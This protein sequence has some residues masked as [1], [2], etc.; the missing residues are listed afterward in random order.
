MYYIKLI[1]NLCT[2]V[3]RLSE[4][5]IQILY[6]YI[7]DCIMHSSGVITF[8]CV[9]VYVPFVDRFVKDSRIWLTSGDAAL[10]T[11]LESDL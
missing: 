4:M 7:F 10:P 9:I 5:M 8:Q 6:L 1:V 2:H 11:I 3:H